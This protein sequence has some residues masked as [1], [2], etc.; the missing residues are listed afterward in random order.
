MGLGLRSWCRWWLLLAL[1][2]GPGFGYAGDIALMRSMRQAD[3]WRNYQRAVPG[4]GS[5]RWAA[6]EPVWGFGASRGATHWGLPSGMQRQLPQSSPIRLQCEEDSMVVSVAADFY[7]IGKLVNPSGLS[8]GPQ[9]CKPNIPETDP[10]VFQ[11][12][13]QDCGNTLKPPEAKEN[14]CYFRVWEGHFILSA[15]DWSGPST[16]NIFKLG[17]I[18]YIEASVFSQNHMDLILFVDSCVAT[19]SPD[20]SSTPRYEIITANGCLVDGMQDDAS[21][22]FISPRVSVD[23]LRF[24]VDAFRFLNLDVSLIYITCSLRVAP[25]TQTPDSMNKACSYSKTT[26]SWYPAEG[27]SSIC[28]CCNTQ[29]CNV[30]TT[31]SRN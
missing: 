11:I 30:P 22:A 9:A 27:S 15:G 24:T 8:L 23:T 18:L 26:N 1:V 31:R 4:R 19:L 10:I 29:N 13:L 21:S 3:R 12:G 28:Q 20:S 7:G 6:P 14:N 17:D 2:C 16:S 25:A 5:S